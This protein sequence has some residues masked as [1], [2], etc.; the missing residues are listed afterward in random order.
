MQKGHGIGSIL[1]SVFRNLLPVVKKIGTR[2]LKSKV[3]K[4]VGKAAAKAALRGGIDIVADT[5][6]GENVKGSVKKNIKVASRKVA[7]SLI[8]PKRPRKPAKK[9]K[10][11]KNPKKALKKKRRTRVRDI[12]D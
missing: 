5:L 9:A 2:I 3:T 7:N 8:T 4:R 12:F 10:A 6:H 1:S 11:K